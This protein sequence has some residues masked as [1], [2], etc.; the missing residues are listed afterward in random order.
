MSLR[1]YQTVLVRLATER[2]F[3][4]AVQ[5]QGEGA[6]AAFD[7]TS[8]ERIRAIGV[9]SD[10]GLKVTAALIS[11]FRLGKILALLPMTRAL[12]GNAR[13]AQELQLFWDT[14]PREAFTLSTRYLSS[15]ATWKR[16]SKADGECRICQTYCRWNVRCSRC[17]VPGSNSAYRFLARSDFNTI[18]R[19]S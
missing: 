1:T 11:S 6:L 3:R 18:R 15:A 8:I 13:L 7:L 5:A 10:P 2:H 4:D 14:H 17:S 19:S 16:D 9:A 12:L